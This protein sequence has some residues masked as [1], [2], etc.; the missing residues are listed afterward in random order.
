MTKEMI[1]HIRNNPK[2]QMLVKKRSR[3]AWTLSIIMLVVYY[4]FILTIAFD[5]QL[6]GTPLEEG[7]VTTIGIPVGIAIIIIAFALTGIYVKRANSEFDDLSREVKAE[8]EKELEK[9]AS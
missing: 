1:E 2:Y 5:P 8:L 6:L 4:A 3:F 7:K 9:D